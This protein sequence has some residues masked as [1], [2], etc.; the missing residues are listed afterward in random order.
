MSK[1]PLLHNIMN[2]CMSSVNTAYNPICVG[3][4]VPL[5]PNS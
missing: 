5:D 3:L 1:T 2:Q 4:D